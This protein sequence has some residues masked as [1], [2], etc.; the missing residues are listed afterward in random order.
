[1]SWVRLHKGRSGGSYW[2]WLGG[3]GGTADR[4]PVMATPVGNHVA[5]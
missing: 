1:M 4:R 2:G 5:F 3:R